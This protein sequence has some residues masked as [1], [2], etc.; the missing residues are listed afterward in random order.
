MSKEISRDPKT[1]LAIIRLDPQE[2]PNLTAA[3]LGDSNQLEIGDWILAMGA[4]FGLRGSVT[5]GIISAKSRPLDVA[6]YEDFI[7]TDAAINPGNSGG[8][9]VDLDGNV[10][11]INT[12]IRSGTG[13][14]AGWRSRFQV[15]WRRLWLMTWY[16]MARSSAASSV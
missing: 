4:P 1:D 3:Q 11:G 14:Y 16:V 2:A 7:Q 12:A 13:T 6:V 10:V 9:L 5:A 15:I 8:P